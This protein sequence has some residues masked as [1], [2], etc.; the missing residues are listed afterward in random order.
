V[1]RISDTSY[2][3]TF[4][5]TS[6][7]SNALTYVARP[8]VGNIAGIFA[9]NT[10]NEAVTAGYRM[11]FMKGIYTAADDLPGLRIVYIASMEA[12]NSVAKMTVW[13]FLAI[14]AT[15]FD[16]RSV[17]FESFAIAGLASLGIMKERF[18]VY[19]TG[20]RA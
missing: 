16:L 18:A 12:T 10:V 14:L 8:F 7:I 2:A 4:L 20:K 3:R 19:N 17:L 15:T 13:F 5:R 1:G 6:A 9:V 11:P